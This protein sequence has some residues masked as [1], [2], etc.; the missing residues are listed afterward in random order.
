MAVGLFGGIVFAAFPLISQVARESH[1]ANERV[2]VLERR[3]ETVRRLRADVAAASSASV[4]VGGRGNAGV[5]LSL[6]AGRVVWLQHEGRLQRSASAGPV[7]ADLPMRAFF[8]IEQRRES[9]R[10][11][12]RYELEDAEGKLSGLALI[13]AG[14]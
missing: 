2:R 13:G 6:P 8:A 10:P 1:E 7:T 9:R 4:I 14:R 12:L 11:F 5:E 3:W